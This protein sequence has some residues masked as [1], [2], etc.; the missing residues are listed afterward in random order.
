MAGPPLNDVRII[1]LE[2]VGA[3][4]FGTNA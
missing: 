4:P 1:A 2:K 3:G